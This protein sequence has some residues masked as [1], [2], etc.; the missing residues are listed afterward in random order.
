MPLLHQ[1]EDGES[2]DRFITCFKQALK[3]CKVS[4]LY[5]PLAAVVVQVVLVLGL[6]HLW[7]RKRLEQTKFKFYTNYPSIGRGYSFGVLFCIAPSL[8]RGCEA[9]QFVV[10]LCQNI[11]PSFTDIPED[12]RQVSSLSLA[13]ALS[14]YLCVDLQVIFVSVEGW[15]KLK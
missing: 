1:V 5:F 8:Q 13:P 9:T 11:L 4:S 7:C 3:F 2:V 6:Y 15:P 14:I 12:G 10:Y